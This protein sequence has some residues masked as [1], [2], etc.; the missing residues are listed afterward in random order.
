MHGGPLPQRHS[1]KM[2][3][4]LTYNISFG[5]EFHA[6]RNEMQQHAQKVNT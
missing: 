6:E 3:K 1:L 4:S 5:S 2:G